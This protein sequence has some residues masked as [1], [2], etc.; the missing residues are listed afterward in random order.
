[1]TI[2]LLPSKETLIECMDLAS[3]PEAAAYL[4]TQFEALLTRKN[5]QDKFQ[6]LVQKF[7]A[8]ADEV[9]LSAESATD[10]WRGQLPLSN[11]ANTNER[12][13]LKG[14][15]EQPETPISSL[16]IGIDFGEKGELNRG[17]MMNNEPV[18]EQTTARLDRAFHAWFARQGLLFRA[19]FVYQA[20]ASGEI[21][22]SSDGQPLRVRLDEF[23]QAVEAEHG[24]L[25]AY[26]DTHVHGVEVSFL[27]V[28]IPET[29]LEA[30][31]TPA[32]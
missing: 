10:L 22:T 2:E 19:P 15:Q 16:A 11:Y 1:M 12:R 27:K 18:D 29:G 21:K 17:Y 13:V 24:G 8:Y 31:A 25:K 30:E 4:A 14:E 26:F 9:A 7:E 20:T 28:N 23:K 6:P 3:T 32:A 5:L